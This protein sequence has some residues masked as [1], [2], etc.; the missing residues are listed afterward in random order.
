MRLRQLFGPPGLGV[1]E[2]R[3]ISTRGRW[4]WRGLPKQKRKRRWL[5]VGRDAHESWVT[6]EGRRLF[7]WAE[8][9]PVNF[10]R[11]IRALHPD[12][13]QPIRQAVLQSL[14]NGGDYVTE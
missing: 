7:G 11:F 5:N 1:W 4:T 2:K 10:E 8:S 9:E 13:R 12:D 6:P 3:W 14:Q